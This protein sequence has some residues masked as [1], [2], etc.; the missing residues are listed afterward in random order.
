[1]RDAP[2]EPTEPRMDEG[3]EKIPVPIIRPTLDETMYQGAVSAKAIT[4]DAHEQCT[5]EDA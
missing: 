4:L 2:T 1:M 5:T 3:V